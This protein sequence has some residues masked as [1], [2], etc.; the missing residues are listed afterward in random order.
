MKWSILKKGTPALEDVFTL[1]QSEFKKLTDNE[2]EFLRWIKEAT[3]Q[4]VY[5]TEPPKS[6]APR[7][8]EPA[9]ATKP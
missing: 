5:Y 6:D 3:A 4:F 2:T 8:V 9:K 7:P 1:T